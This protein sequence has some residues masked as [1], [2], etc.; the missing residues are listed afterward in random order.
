MYGWCDSMVVL[1]WIYGDEARWNTFVSNRV[2][3]IKEVMLPECW[4]YVKSAENPADAACRGLTVAQLKDKSLWWKG[5]SWLSQ[6]NYLEN[7]NP[8]LKNQLM[9]DLPDSRCNPALP[10]Y[11]TGVDYTGFVDVKAS[12]GRSVRTTKGYIVVFVCMVTKAIHLEIVSELT[13]SAFLSALRRMAARR[14]TPKHIYSDNGT[15]FVKTNRIMS[16]EYEQLQSIF[17]NSFYREITDMKI[18]WHFN[19]PAWPTAGGLWER[20]VRSVKYHLK[21]VIGD[22]KLTFE[23]YST[24]LARIE[25][26]LNSRPLCALTESVEDIDCLTPAHFLHG[27]AGTTVIETAEGARTRWQLVT[28]LSNDIWKRWKSEYLIQLSARA[29]W[30]KQQN[31]IQIDDIVIIH[32]DNLP[33]GKWAMGR[34]VELH[35]GGDGMDNN[36]R[37]HINLAQLHH[38]QVELLYYNDVLLNQAREPGARDRHARQRRGLING[39]GYVANTLFGVLDERFAEQYNRMDIE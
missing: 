37:C 25:S 6:H 38:E 2:K 34:V 27:R 9:G 5:P 14:G 32:D 23:E 15:N 33:A 31:N 36:A 35:P 21:R 1:G 4:R 26:C 18:E 30:Q 17:N 7:I 10:F 8:E 3:K 28:K 20:A 12:Q 39:V 19:A 29:K 13:S 16:E 22:Q 24:L 11:H